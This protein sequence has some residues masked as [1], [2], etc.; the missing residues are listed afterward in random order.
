MRSATEKSVRLL[1]ESAE[2]WTTR[3]PCFSCHHQGLIA[4]A[5]DVA[6]QRGF[7]VDTSGRRNQTLFTVRHFQPGVRAAARGGG[8]VGG[9]LTAAYAF[10]SLH[11][12]GA[13]RGDVTESLVQYLLRTQSWDGSWRIGFPDRPPLESSDFAATA[14]SVRALRAFGAEDLEDQIDLRVIVAGRWIAGSEVRTQEDRAF[15]LL[16][17]RWTER[18]EDEIEA[19]AE[20]VLAEQRTDGG[21]AQEEGMDSDA[22]ATGQALVALHQAADVSVTGDPYR[23]GLSFLLDTQRGDGSW[24]VSARDYPGRPANVY[25]ESGFPHRASQFISAAATS[26]AA[27]ALALT[28][29]TRE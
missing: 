9:P 5:V 20:A 16:G 2:I 28:S 1:Q 23:R 11:A 17:L 27:M 19:A 21:W 3:R 4:M 25:F 10:A 13:Q 22:Y 12:N 14:M 15:R 24:L 29:P 8:I 6:R 7:S 26:W 18:D